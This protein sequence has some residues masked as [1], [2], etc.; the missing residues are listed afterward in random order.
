[1]SDPESFARQFGQRVRRAREAAGITQSKLERDAGLAPTTI[2]RI[3]RGESE[4]T[5][6][7]VAR[8]ATVLGV[9]MASLIAD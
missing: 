9:S 2:T 7:D 1:M 5:V 6:Y 8:V 3:E 4:L